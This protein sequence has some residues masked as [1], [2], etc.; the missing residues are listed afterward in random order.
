VRQLCSAPEQEVRQLLSCPRVDADGKDILTV[1]GLAED[2][3]Y[4][5]FNEALIGQGSMRVALTPRK[6]AQQDFFTFCHV[7]PG[8]CSVK[9]TVEEGRVVDIVPDKESGLPNELCPVK[10]GRFSIPESAPP[11][12]LMYPQKRVGSRGE[13]RWE[14][15]SWDEALETIGGDSWR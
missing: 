8:H 2:L 7:C 6:Q 9:A 12:R 3:E 1:E 13:G 14:R 11:D 4:H 10:K 15:I 5:P